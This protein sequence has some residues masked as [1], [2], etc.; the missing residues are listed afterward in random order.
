MAGFEGIVL[1]AVWP[2]K[3]QQGAR[4]PVVPAGVPA[5]ARNGWPV[6]AVGDWY[7]ISGCSRARG[8]SLS[9]L[10]FKLDGRVVEKITNLSFTT[11]CCGVRGPYGHFEADTPT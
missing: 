7:L 4:R 11:L 5:P 9:G 1:W 3:P 8:R 10:L 2:G 6:G